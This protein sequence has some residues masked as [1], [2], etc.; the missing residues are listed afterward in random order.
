MNNED[1]EL[2]AQMQAELKYLKSKPDPNSDTKKWIKELTEILKM[3]QVSGV[4]S[5]LA[6]FKYSFLRTT[7]PEKKKKSSI[8]E[9][10]EAE[11]YADLS[12]DYHLYLGDASPITEF[13]SQSFLN[14][15]GQGLEDKFEKM[16]REELIQAG[17]EY[18]F[19]AEFLNRKC[20]V[21]QKKIRFLEDK[22]NPI[23]TKRILTA[24]KKGAGRVKN[25]QS[26][27]EFAMKIYH[28]L[29][30]DLNRAIEPGDFVEY[31]FRIRE[32]RPVPLFIPKPRLTAEEKSQHLVE[33]SIAREVKARRE[34]SEA[35]LRALF[36]RLSG[37]NTTNKS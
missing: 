10:I 25:F 37:L 12:N 16:D 21:L 31:L 2:I 15:L 22:L 20:D 7:I 28:R 32:E 18:A 24:K 26:D 30:A 34:W 19:G 27:T 8:E 9:I 3:A 4:Q 36:M 35:R 29:A 33:Q 11:D 13:F 5:D 17:L 23:K 6:L 1:K 14:T